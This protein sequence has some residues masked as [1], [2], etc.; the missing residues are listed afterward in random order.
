[1]YVQKVKMASYASCPSDHAYRKTTEHILLNW[2]A[3]I[4]HVL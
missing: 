4:I 3:N 2:N 1:M